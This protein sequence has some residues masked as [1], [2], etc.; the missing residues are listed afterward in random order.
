MAELVENFLRC[1]TQLLHHAQV[2]VQHVAGIVSL[3][4]ALEVLGNHPLLRVTGPATLPLM[5]PVNAT[6][7]KAI[8]AEIEAGIDEGFRTFKVKVGDKECDVMKGFTCYV[9]TK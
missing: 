6:E 9:T 3:V 1:A 5:A 8:A 4:S 2:G 7:A